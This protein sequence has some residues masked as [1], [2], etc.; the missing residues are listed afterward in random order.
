MPEGL[1]VAQAED[2]VAQAPVDHQALE[3]LRGLA[4][5][6][7]PGGPTVVAL[8][9][10]VRGRHRRSGP[11][12]RK[13][14][15]VGGAG[16]DRQVE[17][18]GEEPRLEAGGEGR[19]GG[20]AV[21]G[22]Q[23]RGRRREGEPSGVVEG[24]AP[25]G[26]D[27][28]GHP[29]GQGAPGPAAVLRAVDAGVRRGV[30]AVGLARIHHHPVD[31]QAV[32]DPR[33]GG[34]P[35]S[36][37]VGR[38]VDAG[39]GEAGARGVE[40]VGIGRIDRQPLDVE[41]RLEPGVG[42]RPGDAAVEAPEHTGVAG[43]QEEGR[44]GRGRDE[45]VARDEARGLFGPE[46]PGRGQ[47]LPGGPSVGAPEDPQVEVGARDAGRR[48]P[49]RRCVERFRRQGIRGQGVG[50]V[51]AEAAAPRRPGRAVVQAAEDR[52]TDDGVGGAGRPGREEHGPRLETGLARRIDGTPVRPSVR[53]APERSARAP[54]EQTPGLG[55]VGGDRAA[56]GVVCQPL[57]H[58]LPVGAPVVAPKDAGGRDGVEN[59]R[60]G[61]L[62][63]E[64]ESRLA[65]AGP[66]GA[67]ER[68]P[69]RGGKR[70]QEQEGEGK[71]HRQAEGHLVSLRLRREAA[72]CFYSISHPACQRKSSRPDGGTRART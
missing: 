31:R 24:I 49:A 25:E 3:R 22:P 48:D 9:D 40:Q 37:A 8:E 39:S 72:R 27:L 20:A 69:G 34:S 45:D 23:D 28:G 65:G 66:Q 18:V 70:P 51:G 26:P 16:R 47:R 62:E 12:G 2:R 35:V 41:A 53:A 57:A 4:G 19:P 14:Q 33:A 7:V 58:Q 56:T 32:R 67:P 15:G 11:A 36:A 60:V 5:G 52:S 6:R 42:A 1:A 64:V 44:G 55:R 10:Q 46:L 68:R 43:G 30:E 54:Q 13:V 38:L 50:L 17:D 63:G 59:G 61:R 71:G 29:G 21:G